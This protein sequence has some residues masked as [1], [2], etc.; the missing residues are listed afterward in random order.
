MTGRLNLGNRLLKKNKI[1]EKSRSFKDFLELVVVLRTSN[2]SRSR[3]GKGECVLKKDSETSTRRMLGARPSHRSIMHQTYDQ[4]LQWIGPA[5]PKRLRLAIRRRIGLISLILS[6]PRT[7]RCRHFVVRAWAA[8]RLWY[9]LRQL[10]TQE[11]SPRVDPQH[12]GLPLV[13]I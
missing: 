2:E 5:A 9:L 6:Y 12:S 1:C 7:R 3:Q 10:E 4:R 13:A 11:P 8:R